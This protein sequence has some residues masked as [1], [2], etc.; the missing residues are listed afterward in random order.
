[1]NP[2]KGNQQD[3]PVS[4]KDEFLKM[5]KVGSDE[6]WLAIFLET[7]HANIMRIKQKDGQDKLAHFL[8]MF[9]CLEHDYQDEK[10]SMTQALYQKIEALRN[11]FSHAEKEKESVQEILKCSQELYH[12]LE[13]KLRSIASQEVLTRGAD[14][15]VI[16]D[17][18]LVRRIFISKSEGFAYELTYSG[19]IFLC[20]MALYRDE[21]E[22]FISG[23]K[24]MKKGDLY[25]KD[26]KDFFICFSIR[27][28]YQISG[29]ADF[30]SLH[31]ASVINY[32][33]KV[34]LVSKEYLSLKQ[35]REKLQALE[36]QS[37]EEE[38]N[39]EFKYHLQPRMREKFTSFA[40]AYLEDFDLLPELRFKRLN[41]NDNGREAEYLFG[42]AMK[43]SALTDENDTRMDR[44]FVL[45][46]N[47]AGFAWNPGDQHYG[48]IRIGEIRGSL[49]RD[50]LKKL[51]ALQLNAPQLYAGVRE[52]IQEYLTVY[53]RMLEKILDFANDGSFF[54]LN[55]VLPEL[56]ALTGNTIEE[57]QNDFVRLAT[58]VLGPALVR[59]L[60]PEEKKA[61]DPA[62][63]LLHR[64][65][66]AIGQ[67]H[68]F[69]KRIKTEKI[70]DNAKISEVM[71]FF[72]LHSPRFPFRQLPFSKQHRACLD[73]EFQT[74]HELIGNYPKYPKKLWKHFEKYEDKKEDEKFPAST[75]LSAQET[76]DL[77]GERLELLKAAG[78]LKNA[79]SLDELAVIAARERRRMYLKAREILQ[80]KDA[81]EYKETLEAWQKILG[82]SEARPISRESVFASILKLEE[83]TWKNAYDYENKTPGRRQVTDEEHIYS[84]FLFPA[85]I[86][87]LLLRRENIFPAAS[88]NQNLYNAEKAQFDFNRYF[89]EM[90]INL[91][92]RDFYDSSVLIQWLKDNAGKQSLM[93]VNTL[94]RNQVDSA[95]KKIKEF[96]TQDKLLLKIAFNYYEKSHR[97]LAFTK[98]IREEKSVYEIFTAP[99]RVDLKAYGIQYEVFLADRNK[100]IYGELERALPKF[101]AT[102]K[103]QIGDGEGKIFSF[104]ELVTGYEA[105]RHSDRRIRKMFIMPILRLEKM[106]GGTPP[107]AQDQSAEYL[108][109]KVPVLS[110]EEAKAIT[111]FRNKMMHL[112]NMDLNGMFDPENT[113]K[114][115]LEKCGCWEKEEAPAA[116]RGFKGNRPKNKPQNTQREPQQNAGLRIGDTRSGKVCKVYDWGIL[117]QLD[118][119]N[120]GAVNRRYQ[121]YKEGDSVT[122]KVNNIRMKAG[123]QQI[124]LEI[125]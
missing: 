105:I 91:A 109:R 16:A 8:W 104:G 33:N 27:K 24:H 25:A 14:S 89:R 69:E 62:E 43:D 71:A 110:L 23:L 30:Y 90:K 48:S 102:L 18:S 88:R 52:N 75:K 86:I 45:N 84:R 95:I 66:L 119:K 36:A 65:D 15:A 12:F 85:N 103:A 37:M 81:P 97:K 94:K 13:G 100:A 1:M 26:L 31:F 55:D 112:E 51:I 64:L 98:E 60:Q 92:L 114:P 67:T 96:H 117:V 46:G 6:G 123:K 113:I 32:L 20:S 115:L 63:D 44:H 116:K 76:L 78:P 47:N 5:Y 42:R 72:L 73:Y 61:A 74:I 2:A 107:E 68:Q 11:L 118:K 29:S 35:E 83:E 49:T 106:E 58:P 4:S 108:H 79:S 38:R 57:L 17:R 28:K 70:R 122:V 3:A 41:V 34:P 120:T 77:I 10:E 82:S 93:P 40:L 50:T 7:A 80:Q 87:E 99:I 121:G 59:I 56:V 22:S 9:K 125:V 101:A 111:E 53:H 21:A 39:K 54:R 19:V 124:D